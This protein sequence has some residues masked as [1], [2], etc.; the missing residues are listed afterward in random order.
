M[1][2]DSSGPVVVGDSSVQ[3]LTRAQQLLDAVTA[4]LR[5]MND[6]LESA[7]S[8]AEPEVIQLVRTL[9]QFD[10]QRLPAVPQRAVQSD[11]AGAQKGTGGANKRRKV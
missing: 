8:S 9:E 3:A 5:S 7:L 6:A 10:Q 11:G 2:D 1:G 4:N